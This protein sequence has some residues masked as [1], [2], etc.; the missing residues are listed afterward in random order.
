ML[1]DEDGRLMSYSICSQMLYPC[2]LQHLNRCALDLDLPVVKTS[3]GFSASNF[4]ASHL[5]RS[6]PN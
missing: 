5:G 1:R 2:V 6:P 4:L 3:M